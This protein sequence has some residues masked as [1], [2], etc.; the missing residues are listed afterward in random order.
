MKHM[1]FEYRAV[2]NGW[3]VDESLDWGVSH[4]THMDGRWITVDWYN[5][6]EPGVIDATVI[7]TLQEAYVSLGEE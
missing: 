3:E 6:N 7:C 4:Y 5:M 1:D 2:A